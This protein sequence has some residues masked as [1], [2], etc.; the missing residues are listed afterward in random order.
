M[1][2]VCVHM[3]LTKISLSS[4]VNYSLECNILNEQFIETWAIYLCLQS[5]WNQTF[6]SSQ[7]H[8]QMIIEFQQKQLFQ[9]EILVTTCCDP[10]D[11]KVSHFKIIIYRVMRSLPLVSRFPLWLYQDKVLSDTFYDLSTFR[12]FRSYSSVPFHSG[13]DPEVGVLDYQE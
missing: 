10:G 3:P 13:Y 4:L 7:N 9:R 1:C 6:R 12:T 5:S 8:Q 2:N 11:F